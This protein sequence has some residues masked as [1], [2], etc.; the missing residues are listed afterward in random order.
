MLPWADSS[1]VTESG[2]DRR[3]RIPAQSEYGMVALLGGSGLFGGC[4]GDARMR[5][6]LGIG[7]Y[8]RNGG[9]D[10]LRRVYKKQIPDSR[11][12]FLLN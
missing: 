8:S 7:I 2:S 6:L 4:R 12:G 1:D 3:L 11:Q 5:R 10:F 9:A